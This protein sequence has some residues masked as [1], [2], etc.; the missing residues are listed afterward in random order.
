MH[1]NVKSV[2]EALKICKNNRDL[3]T[4]IIMQSSK[5]YLII[6]HDEM[7]KCFI[8]HQIKENRSKEKHILK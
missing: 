8:C 2:D 7:Y 1:P 6:M 4:H 5:K 3:C